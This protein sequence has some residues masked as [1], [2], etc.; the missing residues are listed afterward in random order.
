[1]KAERSQLQFYALIKAG[2]LLNTDADHRALD[3]AHLIVIDRVF[4]YYCVLEYIWA[5]I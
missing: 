4:N 5:H 3:H 2:L 1:M